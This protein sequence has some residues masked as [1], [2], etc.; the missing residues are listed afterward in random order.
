MRHANGTIS[1]AQWQ[2]DT[3]D[4][5]VSTFGLADFGRSV[6]AALLG[7]LIVMA[8]CVGTSLSGAAA[9]TRQSP[10]GETV[11]KALLASLPADIAA[12]ERR[13]NDSLLRLMPKAFF[14]HPRRLAIDLHQRPY[15]GQREDVP[16]RGGKKKQGTKWFWTWATIAVV[17]HG[18]R[19]TVAMT[20]VGPGDVLENVLT[21][22]LDHVKAAGIPVKMALVDREFYAANVIAV[23]QSRGIAFLMPAIRRGQLQ[24][25]NGP[26]GT[27]RFFVPGTQRLLRAHVDGAGQI[28]RPTGERADRLRAA[29]ARRPSQRAAGFCLLGPRSGPTFVVSRKVPPPLRH[30]NQL[31]P[32]GRRLGP[33]DDQADRV[34]D[35]VGRRGAAVAQSLGLAQSTRASRPGEPLHSTSSTQHTPQPRTRTDPRL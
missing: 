20:P 12:L 8:A 13:I 21:R 25:S 1:K 31:P 19:W 28:K 3:A 16:V 6:S 34:A 33:N 7:R 9:R 18:Q 14:R 4:A 5:I 22:L 26:T 15:Y 23:L 32:V 35:A 30:R 24:G 17:E 10:S 29:A 11:R 27:R 2:Q